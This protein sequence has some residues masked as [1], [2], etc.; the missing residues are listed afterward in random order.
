MPNLGVNF[1]KEIFKEPKHK[2]IHKVVNLVGIF[3]R[4]IDEQENETLYNPVTK[5]ELL[6]VIKSF[7]R[8][9]VRAQMV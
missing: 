8:P 3:P 9:R 5:E 6:V 7:K 4:I 1:F 2:V